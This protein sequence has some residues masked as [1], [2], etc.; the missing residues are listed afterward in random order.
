MSALTYSRSELISQSIPWAFRTRFC[1]SRPTGTVPESEDALS[2]NL[3]L[4]SVVFI[5]ELRTTSAYSALSA[6]ACSASVSYKHRR[7]L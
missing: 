4:K 6:E 7:K 3:R 5:S 2:S 1:T